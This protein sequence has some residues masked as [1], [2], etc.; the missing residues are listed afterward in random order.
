MNRT[1]PRDGPTERSSRGSHWRQRAGAQD[2]AIDRRLPLA[3]QVGD[4]ARIL[5]TAW[6]VPSAD[7]I[8]IPTHRQ[9]VTELASVKRPKRLPPSGEKD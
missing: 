1:A 7:D 3:A 8:V 9:L 2:S 6:M 4:A 5:D